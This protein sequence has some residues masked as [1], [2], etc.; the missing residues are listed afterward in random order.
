MRSDTQAQLPNASSVSCGAWIRLGGCN[1][2]PRG[3]CRVAYGVW[4][5]TLESI[6]VALETSQVHHGCFNITERHAQWLV[7]FEYL[8]HVFVIG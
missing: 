2:R 7:V 1:R 4:R 5:V 3:W 8:I 6:N